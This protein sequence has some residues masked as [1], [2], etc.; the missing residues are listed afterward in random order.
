MCHALNSLPRPQFATT[1]S[2][3]HELV[4]T[5]NQLPRPQLAAT[6]VIPRF[7]STSQLPPT[8][9]HALYSTSVPDVLPAPGISLNLLP[10][11]EVAPSGHDML[12]APGSFPQLTASPSI[13][14]QVLAVILNS[15]TRCHAV[16]SLPRPQLDRAT[17]IMCCQW[18]APFTRC[19]ALDSLP[20]PQSAATAAYPIK[21]GNVTVTSRCT[22]GELLSRALST[23][24]GIPRWSPASSVQFN[25]Q[26]SI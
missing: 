17:A 5:L 23:S 20:R 22:S 7:P 18:L 6:A 9:C 26:F 8:R 16:N 3:C 1:P 15:S 24:P 25:V 13:R 10:R 14:C 11:P 2:F 4:V 21:Q 12:P 19:H